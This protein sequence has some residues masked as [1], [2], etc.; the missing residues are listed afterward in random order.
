VI[1][2]RDEHLD[3]CAA[4]AAGSIDEADRLELE[5]HL[6][7]GCA[8]CARAL[9]AFA[10]GAMHLAAAAPPVAP[11]AS[12]RV[13]VFERVRAEAAAPGRAP[14]GRGV[15][16]PLAA[17]RRPAWPAWALAA[18]AAALAVTTFTLWRQSEDLKTR[19]AGA[20]GRVAQAERELAEERAWAAVLANPG[21]RV[22]DFAP[23]PAAFQVPRVR[24]TYDPKSHRAIV[25]F[26]GAVAPNGK[27]YELWA[28]LPDG[29]KSL[30]VV[31]ADASGH[32]EVRVP[33][34]GDPAALTAFAVSL[35]AAGGSPDPRKPAGPVILVGA[36][37]S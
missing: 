35:E 16:L 13:A 9:A 6:A 12:V 27:D 11:P 1:P 4:L 10:E 23:T 21:N 8:E 14:S 32:A 24:A 20:Q 2:H 34:A 3:L 29:P 17:R 15:V 22:A 36:L 37:K 33:D 7:S 25:A 26:E 5:R 30:G 19:L 18:A 31:H 28:I